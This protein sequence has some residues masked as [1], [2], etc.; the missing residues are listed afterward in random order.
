MKIATWNISGPKMSR[1]RAKRLRDHLLEVDADIL[2]LTETHPYF[3]L[4]PGYRMAASSS[5][6]PDRVGAERWVTIWVR[7]DYAS[8][9]VKTSDPERTACAHVSGKGALDCIVYGL[10]LPWHGDKRHE[11]LGG[12]DAFK[13]A[14]QQQASDWT[15]LA[16]DEPTSLRVVAGDFNQDLLEVGHYYGS[17][18]RREELQKSL[19]KAGLCCLTSGADDPVARKVAGHASVDHICVPR[20]GNVTVTNISIWPEKEDL[21]H[22]LSDHFGVALSLKMKAG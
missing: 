20:D 15:K 18:E 16:Q 4:E 19:N 13:V 3:S 6:A 21:R 10:V 9:A 1:P 22:G 2:V 12:L 11:P 5:E 8:K 7:S 14:L 17:G